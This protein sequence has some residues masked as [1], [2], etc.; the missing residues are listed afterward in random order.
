MI[1]VDETAD[2]HLAKTLEDIRSNP[3]NSCIHFHF[4]FDLEKTTFEQ[5]KEKR[6][7]VVSLIDGC[8]PV[9]QTQVYLCEDGDVFIVSRDITDK[10]AR[11]LIAQVASR[12]DVNSDKVADIYSVHNHADILLRNIAEKQKRRDAERNR[13]LKQK[14]EQIEARQK[15]KILNPSTMSNKPAALSVRRKERDTPEI[16]MIEDDIFSA[17]LVKNVLEGRYKLTIV[18]DPE[19]AITTYLRVAPDLLFLDIGLPH[20]SGHDLLQQI[21]KID[22][23]AYVIMLTGHADRDNVTRSMQTGARGFVAKPFTREKIM[24]YVDRCSIIHK[25]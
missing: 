16:M 7:V 25:T 13:L 21:L 15:E 22:P 2:M 14:Q 5:I 19:Q 8:V 10:A 24:Q 12:L 11:H 9:E 18:T 4:N 23:K 20:V 17:R 1:L 6:D 3:G